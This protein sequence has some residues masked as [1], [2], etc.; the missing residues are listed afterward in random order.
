MICLD[1]SICMKWY[2]EGE[3]FEKL[4]LDLLDKIID[5]SV[6]VVANE[7]INLEVVR[8]L[9]RAQNIDKE[10][11]IT[12]QD[13]KES[14]DDIEILFES[15]AIKKVRVSEVKTLA[16][17]IEISLDL[18]AADAV[19]LATTIFERCE[20]LVTDDNHLLKDD[21]RNYAKNNGVRIIKLDQL[22]I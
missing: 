22:K 9:K 8:G 5:Y 13:I 11:N 16:K 7:W 18:Y 17:E 15:L 6:D 4:A 20:F 19:H 21:V 10:I 1:A 2:K 14:F 3:K 12:N